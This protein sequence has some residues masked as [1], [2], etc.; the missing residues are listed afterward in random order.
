[1][2]IKQ[3]HEKNFIEFLA[4]DFV[5]ATCLMKGFFCVKSFWQ[6][7]QE[8][9]WGSAKKDNYLLDIRESFLSRC[10]YDILEFYVLL[11]ILCMKEYF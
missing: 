7:Y 1:M 5:K 4:T 6:V 9:W 11:K 8:G 2:S 3:E 10:V